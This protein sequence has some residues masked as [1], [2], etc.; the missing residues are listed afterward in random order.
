M[1][2]VF[3]VAGAAI[4]AAAEGRVS[5]EYP[6]DADTVSTVCKRALEVIERDLGPRSTAFFVTLWPDGSVQVSVVPQDEREGI[7]LP[8]SSLESITR[9]TAE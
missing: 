8:L 9:A 4:Y 2:S 7:M 5:D 6:V 3:T 1:Q